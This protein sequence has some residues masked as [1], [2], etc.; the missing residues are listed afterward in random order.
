MQVFPGKPVHCELKSKSTFPVLG[1]S[2]NGE[3][4]VIIGVSLPRPG[5]NVKHA[6]E[7][8]VIENVGLVIKTSAATDDE[9]VVPDDVPGE[10]G[11]GTKIVRRAS[12]EARELRVK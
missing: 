12:R 9:F 8:E 4:P 3:P 5:G 7:Q 1:S 11:L 2:S 6:V 10:P